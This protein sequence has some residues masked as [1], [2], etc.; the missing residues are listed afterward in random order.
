MN[1]KA[2][3]VIWA[4]SFVVLMVFNVYTITSAV[5]PQNPVSQTIHGFVY[6]DRSMVEIPAHNQEQDTGDQ[7][8][9]IVG[10]VNGVPLYDTSPL[11]KDMWVWVDPT[12][13]SSTENQFLWDSDGGVV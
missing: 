3:D 5:F 10:Y 9:F 2:L 11:Y 4:I 12:N 13:P 7:P 1:E 6:S 8:I